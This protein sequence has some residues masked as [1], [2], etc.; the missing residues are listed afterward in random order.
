[1]SPVH[2]YGFL[3]L[4][5][6]AALWLGVGLFNT[7][8]QFLSL[9]LNAYACG[10]Q[11]AMTTRWSGAVIRTTHVTGSATD[12]GTAF[13]NWVRLGDKAPDAWRLGFLIPLTLGYFFGGVG[14]TLLWLKMGYEC[15]A[16]P[17]AWLSGLGLAYMALKNWNKEQ[18]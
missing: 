17:A 7:A 1:M 9:L 14:A 4:I 5:E 16:V 6:S 8:N 2:R 10:L 15:M 12:M 11:N 3:L 18:Q 13:A